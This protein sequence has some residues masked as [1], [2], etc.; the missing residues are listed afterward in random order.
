M[1]DERWPSGCSTWQRQPLP[2]AGPIV[3]DV[4][5][6]TS[7]PVQARARAEAGQSRRGTT[8]VEKFWTRLGFRVVVGVDVDVDVRRPLLLLRVADLHS[9]ASVRFPSPQGH[10][11]FFPSTRS[12][13]GLAM[14]AA[15]LSTATRKA[16]GRSNGRSAAAAAAAAPQRKASGEVGRDAKRQR[17][18][19]G[20]AALGSTESK[21]GDSGEIPLGR[22]LASTG[23]FRQL[24]Y[25]CSA[26]LHGKA[27]HLTVPWPLF[28]P[29]R[30]QSCRPC[31]EEDERLCHSIAGTISGQLRSRASPSNR[32]GQA[33]ERYFLL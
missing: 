26:W 13:L 18:D 10:A 25:T 14:P 9:T 8:R 22:L 20:V 7:L 3:V 29:L 30:L 5:L 33:V 1:R 32:D 21:G 31:R 2:C 12:I 19:G 11:P 17:S 27:G 24:A 6:A 28:M 4:C 15:A 16:N 23:K